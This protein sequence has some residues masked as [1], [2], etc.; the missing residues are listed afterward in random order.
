MKK[1]LKILFIVLA[2]LA[3]AVAGL[4]A[5]SVWI[6]NGVD[7]S[8]LP[9]AGLSINGQQLE[10]AGYEWY[11]EVFN[12]P[13]VEKFNSKYLMKAPGRN[14]FDMGSF[15]ENDP[16][17][18]F[19][20]DFNSTV[21]IFKN[22]E[23]AYNGST[24]GFSAE[25]FSENAAYSVFVT[26]EKSPSE[27]G[28]YGKIFFRAEFIIDVP[29]PPAP[30]PSFL[31][32]ENSLY[33]GEILVVQALHIEGD[34][35]PEIETELGTAIFT[36]FVIENE[37]EWAS[38]VS[39][40]QALVPIG[41]VREPGAYSLKIRQGDRTFFDESIAVIDYDFPFQNLII[42][43]SSSS[44]SEA[45]SAKAYAQFR[46]KINPLRET[47]DNEQYWE[48]AFQAPVSGRISTEFGTERITNGKQSTWRAH[49]GM[50]IAAPEGTK[51]ED[52]VGTE[53]QAP[54]N[55]R[56]VFAEYLLNTGYTIVIEH[57]GGL[58][59]YYFHMS[60]IQ[61]KENDMVKTGDIIGKVGSTG[62]SSGPH[63]HYEMRIGDQAVDPNQFYETGPSML[64]GSGV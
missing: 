28:S 51:P 36:P 41:N 1:V 64:Y 8:A 61:V 10:A 46:E 38:P 22:G 50:D 60:E 40:W 5:Y 27:A 15:N 48:G 17:F 32:S 21:Q 55:G 42:D 54:N 44:V 35:P 58:K 31:I 12:F 56:V 19:P 13:F 14:G 57:G 25:L 45:S 59:T 24:D 6:Y 26:S 11:A 62:Y 30:A 52:F 9:E 2:I 37:P 23:E 47:Y 4:C 7:E 3:V 34:A 33:Q 63:L 49:Y 39:S 20:D 29:P 16:D 43:T 53:I 18:S